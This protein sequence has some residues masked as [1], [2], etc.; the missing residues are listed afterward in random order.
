MRR[1]LAAVLLTMLLAPLLALVP[2]TAHAQAPDAVGWWSA[3]HRSA[4]PVVPPAPPDVDPGD[5]LLQ[6]GDLQRELPGTAPAPT[7]YA[8][9]RYALPAGGGVERLTLQVAT[10]AQAADVRAYTT[11]ASWQPVENGAIDDAPAA[12]LS[13]YAVGALSGDGQSLVFDDIGKLATESGLLS[14][15]LVPGVGDRVVVLKPGPA[16][17]T[18]SEAPGAAEPPAAP[19]VAP[20]APAPV[21]AP[22]PQ[23]ALPV[24]PAAPV[25]PPVVPTVVPPPPLIE[26]R[27]EPVTA[28]ST[29][30]VLVPDDRRTRLVVGLEALLLTVFFGLLGTGPLARLRA[31]P[32]SPSAERGLGRFRAVREGAA[33]RL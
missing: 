14:V 11:T 21:T 13:R 18:V 28:S 19:P 32:D 20:P 4:V 9:L 6:G 7:A 10:G 5:L 29:R 2:G 25:A 8:A 17:L 22:L 31:V 30:R 16:A 24:A 1:L 27:A 3:A 12:D 26:P 15:V 23:A 33:P